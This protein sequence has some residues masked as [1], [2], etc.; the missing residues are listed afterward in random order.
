M[1]FQVQIVNFESVAK[2]W[3]CNKRFLHLNVVTSATLWGLWNFR[4]SIV[5]NRVSWI[6]LKQVLGLIS[7][8]LRDWTK[9]F[10][11]LQGGAL[12]DFQVHLWGRLKAPFAL[13]PD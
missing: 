6:S 13:E 12:M 2:L 7:R 10:Q 4:N 1:I 8:Y 9:P 3:L 11:D 5:F